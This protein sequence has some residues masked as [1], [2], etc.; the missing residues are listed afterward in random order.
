MPPLLSH[1]P[2]FPCV[3]YLKVS[4]RQILAI[5]Y[6]MYDPFLYTTIACLYWSIEPDIC[7]SYLVERFQSDICLPVYLG[8]LAGVAGLL[9]QLE[10]LQVDMGET[11]APQHLPH[12]LLLLLVQEPGATL[13]LL[14]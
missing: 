1:L 12:L 4:T 14:G 3:I 7:V 5:M 8:H 9:E 11:L 2:K 13:I 10:P 6:D